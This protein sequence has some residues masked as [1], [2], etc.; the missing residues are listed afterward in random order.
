M[1]SSLNRFVDMNEKK[2]RP[3]KA[4]IKAAEGRKN[5]S[6][7]RVIQRNLVYVVG[8]PAALADDEVDGSD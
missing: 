8:I 5:L 7:V 4:K 3:G 2:Q 1:L 6:N